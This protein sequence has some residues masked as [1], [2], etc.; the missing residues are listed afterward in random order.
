VLDVG[1]LTP[2]RRDALIE[3]ISRFVV[4]RRLE[5]PAVFMLESSRPLTFVGSQAL[6]VGQPVLA[7]FFGWERVGEYRLLLE[8]RANIDRLIARIESLAERRDRPI[9]PTGPV[10]GDAP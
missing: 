9:E 10:E 7:S 5:T 8:D 1:Q 4:D 2:E 3:K 6:V